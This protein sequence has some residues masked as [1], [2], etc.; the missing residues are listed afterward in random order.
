MLSESLAA[1][2]Q[3]AKEIAASEDKM[4]LDGADGSNKGEIEREVDIDDLL[5]WAGEVR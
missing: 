4:T 5:R 2:R 1:F 3:Q